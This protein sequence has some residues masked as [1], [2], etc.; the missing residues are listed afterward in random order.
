LVQQS[1]TKEET[2]NEITT[3]GLDL[4]KSVFH[5]VCCN[6]RGKIIRRKKLSRQQVIHFFTQL[7]PCLVG[8]EACSTSHY[9]ARELTKLGHEVKQVPTQHVKAFLRGNKNDYND[10][11]AIAEAVVRPEMRFVATKTVAQQDSQSLGRYRQSLIRSRTGTSNRM[12]ALLAEHGVSVSRGL[13][14]LR[15][16]LPTLIENCDG[17]YS[18]ELLMMLRLGYQHLVLLDEQITALDRTLRR[19]TREDPNCQRLEEI[20][21]FGPVSAIAFTSHVGDGRQ[22]RRGRDVSASVG[23]VPGQYSTGGRE[24]LLGI[25]KRGNKALR[26]LLIHGARSAIRNVGD[27]QDPISCW[28]RRTVA[29]IG[30]HKAIVAYANKMARIGWSLLRNDSR[31]DPNYGMAATA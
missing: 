11:L 29:R 31:F 24:V 26:T 12:R 15:K 18:E 23:I 25:S 4:A 20:P 14:V 2:V 13:S 3:I 9:W 16:T 28:I 10:A 5:V 22:F 21:G 30:I 8:V 6:R 1:S 17:Q 19:V 7:T 27:K